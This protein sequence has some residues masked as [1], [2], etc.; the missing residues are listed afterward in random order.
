M[1]ACGNLGKRNPQTKKFSLV[2][3]CSRRPALGGPVSHANCQV[4]LGAAR[5][6]ATQLGAPAKPARCWPGRD[7]NSGQ[8]LWAVALIPALPK[9]AWDFVRA[10]RDG[11]GGSL[12]GNSLNQ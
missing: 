10:W 9:T 4:A 12:A 5:P 6:V 3:L 1:Q 8:R 2:Q 11:G 7:C